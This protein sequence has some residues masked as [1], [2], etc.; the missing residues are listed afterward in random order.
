MRT[1]AE[2]GW[3]RLVPVSTLRF[4]YIEQKQFFSLI[5]VAAH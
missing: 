1:R 5:F 3:A 2:D 4:I